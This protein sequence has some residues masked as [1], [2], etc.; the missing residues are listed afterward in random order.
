M[1]VLRG[2]PHAG[3]NTR[4]RG[5]KGSQVKSAA[6]NLT[7]EVAVG[8]EGAEAKTPAG[9]LTVRVEPKVVS[10]TI[11]SSV[12]VRRTVI[13]AAA[14]RPEPLVIRPTIYRDD[15]VTVED[16]VL[17]DVR[18]VEFRDSKEAIERLC[19]AIQE[20]NQIAREV[21][22]KMAAEFRA[23]LEY[24]AGPKPS[25]KVVDLLLVNP[26]Y[27]AAAIF[28]GSVVAELAKLALKALFKLI[29]PG[30]DIPL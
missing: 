6:G 22:D 7:R 23:G 20:S 18:S 4:S 16:P 15:T 1:F 14:A 10:T 13:R 29:S 24:I 3:P 26:L 8:L 30:I 21:G 12:E 19:S 17:I 11:G 2:Y 28:A 27:A 25:R 9:E 5:M